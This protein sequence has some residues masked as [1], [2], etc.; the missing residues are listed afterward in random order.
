L[1]YLPDTAILNPLYEQLKDPALAPD[2]RGNILSILGMVSVDDRAHEIMRFVK[3]PSF[4]RV[5]SKVQINVMR[6]L[7]YLGKR[8][9]LREQEIIELLLK[10]V[11][12]KDLNLYVGRSITEALN[13]LKL[14]KYASEKY[15]SDLLD[16]LDE[17]SAIDA[18]IRQGV[19]QI[20]SHCQLNE[21]QQQRLFQLLPVT[22]IPNDVFEALMKGLKVA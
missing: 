14:Q 5:C 12:Q 21:A 6:T 1:S 10:L 13:M 15:L 11:R 16:L 3:D 8:N 18:Y 7:G 17:R 2:Q 9:N 4:A 22:D 20:I 19:A